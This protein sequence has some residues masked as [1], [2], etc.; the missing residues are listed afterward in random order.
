MATKMCTYEYIYFITCK[1]HVFYFV[2]S[3]TINDSEFVKFLLQQKARHATI[4][5]FILEPAEK[6]RS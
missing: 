3:T 2:G 1:I 4:S 5:F 6:L